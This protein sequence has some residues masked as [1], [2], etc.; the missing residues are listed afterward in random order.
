MRRIGVF[1]QTTPD[2]PTAPVRV[3]MLSQRLEG[4]AGESAGTSRLTTASGDSDRFPK[5]AAELIALTPDVIVAEVVRSWVLCSTRTVPILFVQV[6]DPV[7][8]GRVASLSRP[9]G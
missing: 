9:G 6:T 2:D 5:Y 1:I 8:G 4:W 7:G 3:A